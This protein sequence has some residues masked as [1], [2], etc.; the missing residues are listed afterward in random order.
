M[1]FSSPIFLFLF[2]P[3]TLLLTSLAPK[4]IKNYILLIASLIFYAW[5]GV[6]Y[7]I[8]ML[9]SVSINFV[10]GLKINKYNHDNLKRKKFIIWGIA[11]NLLLLGIFKYTN[12]IVAS[13]ND[14]LILFHFR[15]IPQTSIKLPIGISFFTFQ[16]MSYIIDVYRKETVVQRKF[17]DLA[18]YVSLFPQL[19][20]GPI[21]RYHDVALQLKSRTVSIDKFKSG[22]QRF[23]IGLA[24][25]VL[26][27]N[28]FAAIADDIFATPFQNL[29]PISAW[30]GVFAYSIQIYYDFSGYSDMAIGLGRM[31]GF[32]FLENFNFPY[33]SK[34]IKEFWTRWHISLSSWFRDYLYI[35]LGGNRNGSF[36]T[37][38]NL[39]I[40]FFI[41]GFW[42]GA[43]LNFIIW[44]LFHGFFIIIERIGL[45]KILSKIPAPISNIYTLFVVITGWVLFRCETLPDSAL[46]L[47]AMFGLNSIVANPIDISIFI[48]KETIIAMV[49]AIL[50]ASTFFLKIYNLKNMIF[51]KLSE[52]SFHLLSN[53]FDIC[54]SVFLMLVLFI[55]TLYLLSNTYNP[56]I[57]FRF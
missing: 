12:F 29:D 49:I 32:E 17:S 46:Y 1:L 34:S 7:M 16:A 30:F 9:F 38:R 56:F 39:I 48:N 18:L 23:I 52:K 13:I 28:T 20:A 31:F 22:I 27:A 41:T 15:L 40:V 55:C 43:S 8:L 24:R 4:S 42:H 45:G 37:Y 54:S 5:G 26:I 51:Q 11:I 47:K 3:I 35:P 44:G 36:Y 50:G 33:I 57:Y 6:Y 53:I 21:V 14:L 10:F 25:K 2:L 19:I